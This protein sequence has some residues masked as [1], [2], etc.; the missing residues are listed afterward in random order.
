MGVR[1]RGSSGSP[2]WRDKVEAAGGAS[3]AAA[4]V[5]A[6]GL[7]VSSLCRG[8]FFPAADARGH[9][10]AIEENRRAIEE[11]ATLG[12]DVLV[13]VCG[14]LPEGSRDLV[15]V[16][17]VRLR[18]GSTSWPGV[19]APPLLRRGGCERA[20]AVAAGSSSH[21][22]RASRCRVLPCLQG[23]TSRRRRRSSPIFASAWVPHSVKVLTR[24]NPSVRQSARDRLASGRAV[25]AGSGG[26]PRPADPTAGASG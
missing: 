15:V 4:A 3:D 11:A 7:R 24:V 20:Q 10:A 25:M 5:R 16:D 2:W 21:E 13:L 22:E 12:A 23:T 17:G 9:S 6:A 19:D 14:G 1:A 26:C 18:R 8:G